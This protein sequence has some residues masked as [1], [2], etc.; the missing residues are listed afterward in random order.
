MKILLFFVLM[1]SVSWTQ[2]ESF[3]IASQSTDHDTSVVVIESQSGSFARVHAMRLS[4]KAVV[5]LNSSDEYGIKWELPRR[6]L[7]TQICLF[8]ARAGHKHHTPILTLSVASLARTHLTIM[9]RS[10]KIAVYP[11]PAS[12]NVLQVSKLKVDELVTITELRTGK[13]YIRRATTDGVSVE[14]IPDG[15][16]LLFYHQDGCNYTSKVILR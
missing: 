5:R 15:A 12:T 13:Q 16:Y 11:N 3:S 8:G 7:D 10:S 14:G 2:N 4:D 6:L 1:S 9:P